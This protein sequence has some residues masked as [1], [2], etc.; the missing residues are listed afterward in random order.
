MRFRQILGG[1]I[2][3]PTMLAMPLAWIS[4]VMLHFYTAIVAYGL[5][6][7]D[8]GFNAYVAAGAAFT[9]PIIAEPVVLIAAWNATG[10]FVNGYSVWLLSWF[11]YVIT[12]LS[13]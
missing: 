8:A 5:A 7:P 4:G 12:L 2:A 9:F 10:H 13:G 3:V 6:G 1:I 11:T